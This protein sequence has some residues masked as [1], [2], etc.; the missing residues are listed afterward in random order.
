VDTRALRDVFL[1]AARCVEAGRVVRLEG[2]LIH[3]RDVGRVMEVREVCLVLKL[4]TLGEE[5]EK[6]LSRREEDE[7]TSGEEEGE[8]EGEVVGGVGEIAERQGLEASRHL[9]RAI[10]AARVLVGDTA[11]ENSDEMCEAQVADYEAETDDGDGAV[12][13]ASTRGRASEDSNVDMED[14]PLAAQWVKRL[15]GGCS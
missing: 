3:F 5:C 10:K 15:L 12:G 8:V 7:W 11:L 1:W 14:G 13:D 9:G 2:W 6:M 4:R